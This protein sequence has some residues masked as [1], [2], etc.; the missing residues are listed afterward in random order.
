MTDSTRQAELLDQFLDV[1]LRE[2]GYLAHQELDE[3]TARFA[4]AVA[5]VERSVA[6]DPRVRDR[7][8]QRTLAA[9]RAGG[10]TLI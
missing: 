1:L 7:V 5:L 2:P 9:A 8:W 6:P 4:R 10:R 3:E